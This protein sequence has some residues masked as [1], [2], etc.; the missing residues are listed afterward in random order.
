MAAPRLEGEVV[1]LVVDVVVLAF[2]LGFFA[3]AVDFLAVVEETLGLVLVVEVG[4]LAV[5]DLGFAVVIDLVVFDLV[6]EETGFGL[7]AVLEVGLF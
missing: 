1:F 2:G 5:E 6:V 3:V 7:V 4:F